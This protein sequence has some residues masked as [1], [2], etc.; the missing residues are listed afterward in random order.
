MPS[1][2]SPIP[3]RPATPTHEPAAGAFPPVLEGSVPAWTFLSNH[4]HVL[5]CVAR[6][7][8]VRVRHMALAVGITERAVQRILAELEEAGVLTHERLG[9][10][11]R[12]QI[13]GQAA[14]RHP[15]EAHRTVEDLLGLLTGS[16][17][18]H[19]GGAGGAAK[20]G[21]GPRAT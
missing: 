14:L 1:A 19:A 18:G 8:N 10:R 3:R 17:G 2:K 15:L 21:S 9:R 12:Y 4:A 5:L 7:P 16:L 6:D 13:H 11:N 20:R